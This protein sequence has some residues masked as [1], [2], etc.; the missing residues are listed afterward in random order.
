MNQYSC[1]RY[2]A[3][4]IFDIIE[5]AITGCRSFVFSIIVTNANRFTKIGY[6]KTYDFELI[7]AIFIHKCNRYTH[8]PCV[9]TG[10]IGSF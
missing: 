10:N 4:P 5:C 1:I 6:T 8:Y 3:F 9:I 2:N 7:R